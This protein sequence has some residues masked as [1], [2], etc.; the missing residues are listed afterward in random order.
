MSEPL[1]SSDTFVTL[2]N[3]ACDG[4]IAAT[5]AEELA[6]LLIADSK[7]RE[8]YIEHL[9]LRRHVQSLYRAQRVCDA[10]LARIQ[11]TLPDAP[12]PPSPAP[13]FVA[14]AFHDTVSYFSSGWPVAYLVATAIVGI[15]LAA[16][17][18]V[19]VQQPENI[20]VTHSVVPS[21]SD[22]PLTDIVSR[23]TAV[24][25]CQWATDGVPLLIGDAVPIGRRIDLKSGLMEITYSTGAKV[26]L[27]G[28]VKYEVASRNGGYLS[29][30]R[31]TGKVTTETARGLTIRTPTATVTDLGTEF[32]VEV[33]P[34]KGQDVIVY[35]GTVRVVAQNDKGAS[36]FERILHANQTVRIHPKMNQ[37]V[38][39]PT[40][41]TLEKQFVRTLAT[42]PTAAPPDIPAY[43]NLVLWLKANAIADVE[44]G[45]VLGAWRDSSPARNHMYHV[46]DRQ[47]FWIEWHAGCAIP[48]ESAV[49]R[50]ARC[51]P[52]PFGSPVPS[53]AVHTSGSGSKLVARGRVCRSRLFRRWKQKD[54]VWHK[55]QFEI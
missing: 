26:I 47:E 18:I 9:Q 28:P 39:Q 38:V 13:T 45:A 14:T 27:Q 42:P 15:G 21:S 16:A 55:C 24:V 29:V 50:R 3:D 36:A 52:S 2:L 46:S 44:D 37:L 54:R 4:T 8:V 31:L 23:V 41:A 30:G 43:D 5:Q 51:R 6:N 11:A 53:A 20:A 34:D 17:A 12:Q 7:A 22:R 33:R 10:G 48:R 19:H 35:Q 49:E 1:S 32:G 25:G 40:S